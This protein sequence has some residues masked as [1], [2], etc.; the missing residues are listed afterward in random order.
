VRVKTA[1]IGFFFCL[2]F[3]NALTVEAAG[4]PQDGIENLSG[5]F[6]TVP[7]NPLPGEI[8]Y[9]LWLIAQEGPPQ[10][11]P[12]TLSPLAEAAAR[13]SALIQT[14]GVHY[15]ETTSVMGMNRKAEYWMKGEKFK[16]LDLALNEVTL[17]DGKWFY[18]YPAKGK[19]C[20]RLL[21]DDPE[22]MSAIQ[23]VRGY[24]LSMVANAPYVQQEDR[25]IKGYD[26]QVFYRDVDMG[27][28]KGN[29]LFVDKQT[30]ALLK[31]QYGEGK[32]S[33][34][35]TVTKLDTGTFGDEAFVLPKGVKVTGL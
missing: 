26:C 34:V 28:M 13:F 15:A 5:A 25:E 7:A 19:T 29:W 1:V 22:A 21:P 31:N 32:S 30:G 33:M 17:F 11:E 14:E 4:T 27:D 8:P 6:V 35:T 2:A 12:P 3:I 24:M 10:T 23:A 16:K 20:A 9:L 18:K